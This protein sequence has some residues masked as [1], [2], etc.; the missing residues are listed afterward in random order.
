M[1]DQVP[2]NVNYAWKGGPRASSFLTG[3]T[4]LGRVRHVDLGHGDRHRADQ[5]MAIPPVPASGC[6]SRWRSTAGS[7][8]ILMEG[9]GDL[10]V[11]RCDETTRCLNPSL[12]RVTVPADRGF[13]ARVAGSAARSGRRGT[14]GRGAAGC[15]A[16]DW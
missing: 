6:W 12:G 14:A 13:R 7:R 5:R 1:A 4:Q 16:R 3:D 8:E 2:V 9:G 10:P 15:R 11:Y